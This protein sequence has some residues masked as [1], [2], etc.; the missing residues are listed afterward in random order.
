MN[1]LKILC[2]VFFGAASAAWAGCELEP[3]QREALL[4][5]S[6]AEASLGALKP[7]TLYCAAEHAQASKRLERA[8]DLYAHLATRFPKHELSAEA[9]KR[10]ASLS[11]HLGDHQAAERHLRGYLKR[12]GRRKPKEAAAMAMAFGDALG[13]R[14]AWSAL[15]SHAQGWLKR[16]PSLDQKLRLHGQL[17]RAQ[18]GL[19]QSAKAE[20]SWRKITALYK[21]ASKAQRAN[22]EAAGRAVVAEARFEE[23]E[24][25]FRRLQAQPMT[26]KPTQD[27]K[28]HIRKMTT[29]IKAYMNRVAQA[30]ALYLEVVGLR[31]A[32]WAL[33]ALTRIGQLY[34]E[35]SAQLRAIPPPMS[36]GPGQAKQLR[37]QM[38][39]KADS[40]LHKAVEAYQ[41]CVEK[42]RELN[43]SNRWSALAEARLAQLKPSD[44]RP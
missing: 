8:R 42:A 15:R 18:R 40:V 13:Q 26:F 37:A 17:A 5:A 27:L 36:F 11:I 25:L 6:L 19:N 39:E 24:V 43:M 22:L 3:A 4:G 16:R 44:A 21:R 41:V 9:L 28:Q 30:R 29:A 32:E 20:T 23:A 33:A 10:A 14:A 1:S 12:F 35:T 2:L 38:G 7:A 34:E 31:E